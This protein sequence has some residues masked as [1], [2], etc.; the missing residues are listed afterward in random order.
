MHVCR[1]ET[2]VLSDN[3]SSSLFQKERMMNISFSDDSRKL[4]RTRI[5]RDKTQASVTMFAGIF[6][7]RD[8]D[9][10]LM[11]EANYIFAPFTVG[12]GIGMSCGFIARTCCLRTI[13]ICCSQESDVTGTSQ[14]MY[15]SLGNGSFV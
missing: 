8:D 10:K 5:Y 4:Q 1:L 14:T 6:Q 13:E 7:M 3:H 9:G 2:K 12:F 11:G 15:G